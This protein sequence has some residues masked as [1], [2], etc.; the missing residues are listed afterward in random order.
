M[1]TSNC[2]GD[3]NHFDSDALLPPRK[4][5]LAGLKR[6][7]SDVTVPSTSH[8]GGDFEFT[9]RFN[10]S[11]KG[12]LADPRFSNDDIVEASKSDAIEAAKNAELARARAETKAA[13]A[14]KAMAAAR[15]ALDLVAI[16]SERAAKREKSEKK[17]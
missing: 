1:N 16:L 7:S 4:R 17:D 6:Q 5:L 15:S 12:R 11:L 13:K 8:V 9:A 3:V 10:S 14:A 2:G